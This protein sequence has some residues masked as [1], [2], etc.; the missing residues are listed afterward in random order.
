MRYETEEYEWGVLGENVGVGGIYVGSRQGV[1]FFVEFSWNVK[2][3]K[4]RR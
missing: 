3:L 2:R 1:G 4:D